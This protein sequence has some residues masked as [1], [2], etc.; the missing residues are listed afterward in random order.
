MIVIIIAS[1]DTTGDDQG[2]QTECPLHAASG[3]AGCFVVVVR[4]GGRRGGRCH[5]RS[6]RRANGRR[7]G[8]GGRR[9]R[10]GSGGGSA[11]CGGVGVGSPRCRRGSRG[12]GGA[13]EPEFGA[14]TLHVLQLRAGH[15]RRSGRRRGRSRGSRRSGGRCRRRGGRGTVDGGGRFGRGGNKRTTI[16]HATAIGAIFGVHRYG[17]TAFLTGVYFHSEGIRC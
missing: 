9:S 17:A 10:G 14:E 4:I 2:E 12:G 5:G 16:D 6:G 13:G 15:R 11:D 1:G 3:T 7:F 8:C